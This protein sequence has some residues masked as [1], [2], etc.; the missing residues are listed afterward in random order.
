MKKAKKAALLSSPKLRTVREISEIS[1]ASLL[2]EK[3]DG[4]ELDKFEEEDNVLR[5]DEVPMEV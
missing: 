3:E 2:A 1:G 4:G 5:N